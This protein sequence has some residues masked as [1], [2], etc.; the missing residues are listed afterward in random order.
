MTAPVPPPARPHEPA[1]APQPVPPT[2]SAPADLPADASPHMAQAAAADRPTRLPFRGAWPFLAG[3]AAGLLM[4]FLFSGKPGHAYATMLGSFIYLSPMLVGAVTVYAAER[5]RRRSWAY[6]VW[7]PFLANV[8]YVVGTLLIMVEGLICAAVI[9]PLF[10]LLGS[11]GGLAMGVVCRVTRWPRPSLYAFGVLPL[12]LG[13]V[14]ARIPLPEREHAVQRSLLIQATPERLW[15]EIHNARVIRPEEVGAAW[16]FRIGVPLPEAGVSQTTPQGR[17]REIRMGRAVHFEQ[18]V[19]DWE[20][21]R[22]VRWRHRYAADSFPPQAL[23]EHVLLGGHYFDIDTS[24]YSLI[25]RG[26]ATELQVTMT[27]RVST[28]FNWYADPLARWMLGNFEEVLLRFYQR[29][30]EVAG[31]AT[32]A[33]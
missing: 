31:G 5:T 20:E 3:I 15:H 2:M 6:Y 28:P 19:L 26:A 9:I 25:A 10:A 13:A 18:V 22:Q 1:P 16:F 30:S 17:V 11:V 12:V 33:P 27:Y 21:H 7:A 29:R 23:D 24:A 8:L 32:G 4:R 14:E